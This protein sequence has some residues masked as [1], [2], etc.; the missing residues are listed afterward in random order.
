MSRYGSLAP[1]TKSRLHDTEQTSQKASTDE[2]TS[3]PEPGGDTVVAAHDVDTQYGSL[4]DIEHGQPTRDTS[5]NH[6]SNEATSATEKQSS[7]NATELTPLIGRN[8]PW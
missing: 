8:L 3:L 6:S 5:G 2:P 4:T 7:T 1:I